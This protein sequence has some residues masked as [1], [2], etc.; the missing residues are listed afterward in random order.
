[1]RTAA[2]GS[3]VQAAA[4]AAVDVVCG[5]AVL[6]GRVIA[7]ASE[8]EGVVAV[9]V[10]VAWVWVAVMG[11]RVTACVQGAGGAAAGAA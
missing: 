10:A 5:V 11:G 6:D 1:M 8:G 2:A 7:V 9:V 4:A 3:V